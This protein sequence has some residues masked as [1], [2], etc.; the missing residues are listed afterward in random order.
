MESSPQDVPSGNEAIVRSLSTSRSQSPKVDAVSPAS[1]RQSSMHSDGGGEALQSIM[2]DEMSG[3][4]LRNTQDSSSSPVTHQ[5][6]DVASDT[7]EPFMDDDQTHD[8]PAASSLPISPGYP[9]GIAS[10]T[11]PPS[12]CPHPSA[13]GGIPS[14]DSAHCDQPVYRL[15]DDNPP[16]A[17]SPTHSTV[18]Q[19]DVSTM[20]RCKA[21]DCRE[22]KILA[23]FLN[24]LSSADARRE[25]EL[26][27]LAS[28]IH[29][30]ESQLALYQQENAQLKA[31]ITD[32]STKAYTDS[33]IQHTQT[34][35]FTEGVSTDDFRVDVSSPENFSSE[36]GQSAGIQ[37]DT[38]DR[39]NSAVPSR[40]SPI[41]PDETHDTTFET[42]SSFP[43]EY[44]AT[45]L[46]TGQS[47]AGSLPQKRK[48]RPTGKS[49]T[50]G[51][52]NVSASASIVAGP[53]PSLHL[54]A[55][56]LSSLDSDKHCLIEVAQAGSDGPYVHDKPVAGQSSRGLTS[57]ALA[58]NNL[59]AAKLANMAPD[60]SV[61]ESSPTGE[62]NLFLLDQRLNRRSRVPGF[63]VALQLLEAEAD[64]WLEGQASRHSLL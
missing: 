4:L 41:S 57:S 61:W 17:T 14:S 7:N 23:V 9:A 33:S 32:R 16:T 46:P 40:S 38:H 35:Q 27:G 26:N 56:A 52:A 48:Y 55:S 18:S 29:H 15:S 1:S 50:S 3:E 37:R 36:A 64:K 42:R 60:H 31:L 11:E 45:A 19:L 51:Q 44:P 2:A 5:H 59:T 25:E 13:H 24:W 21:E 63:L 62:D 12:G 28:K 58:K 10:S 43:S 8:E 54:G 39:G 6:K 53:S 34:E 22:A 47:Q 49:N 30:L 20:P